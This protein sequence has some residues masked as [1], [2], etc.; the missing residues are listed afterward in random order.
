MLVFR[1]VVRYVHKP[2]ISFQKML[3]FNWVNIGND[4]SLY[5]KFQDGLLMKL[6]RKIAQDLLDFSYPL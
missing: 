5:R 6:C 3:A 2:H 4:G 1:C